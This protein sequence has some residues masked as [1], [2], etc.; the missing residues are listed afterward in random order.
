MTCWAHEISSI[1]RRGVV[2]AERTLHRF[3]AERARVGGGG[4]VTTPV[5]MSRRAASWRSISGTWD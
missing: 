1:V 2:V 5:M 3:A 4:K